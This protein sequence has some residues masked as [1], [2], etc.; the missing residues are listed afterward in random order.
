MRYSITRLAPRRLD[1]LPVQVEV[2][3]SR[4]ADG[5]RAWRLH[6][7]RT[8]VV[9]LV[10][11]DDELPVPTKDESLVPPTARRVG[12]VSF[13]TQRRRGRLLNRP[14]APGCLRIPA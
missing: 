7:C 10:Q 2:G 9:P 14:R 3:M 8:S 5:A 1:P 6:W 11:R 13:E 4:G 12:E